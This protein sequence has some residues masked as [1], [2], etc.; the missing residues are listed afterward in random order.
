MCGRLGFTAVLAALV[1]ATPAA[2]Q[3]AFIGFE[4][5]QLRAGDVALAGRTNLIVVEFL[6]PKKTGLGKATAAL[7]FKDLVATVGDQPGAGVLSASPPI[8]QRIADF[9]ERDQHRAAQRIGQ[10]QR[11]RLVLWGSIEPFGDQLVVNASLT[12]LAATEDPELILQLA[13]QK[14]PVP[15]VASELPWTR[16][17]L[18]P[19][20]IRRAPYF[21][22]V[23]I[24]GAAGV[25]M[26]AAPE[27]SA[28]VLRTA[29]PGE[30]LAVRDMHEEWAVLADG[31]RRVF[32]D[33]KPRPD[34]GAAFQVM[35]RRVGVLAV[36]PVHAEPSERAAVVGRLEPQRVYAAF[37]RRSVDGQSWLQVDA[38]GRRGWIRQ[39]RA[40][41]VHDIAAV[42]LA[43]ASLRFAF[44]NS[45]AAEFELR[46]F[47]ARPESER[48]GVVTAGALQFLAATILRRPSS[49]QA[50]RDAALELLDRAVA[51]TPYDASALN[52]RAVARLGLRGGLAAIEDLEAALTIDP[53]NG[54]ARILAA[55]IKR[56]SESSNPAVVAQLKLREPEFL[57]RLDGLMAR[58]AAR[59]DSQSPPRRFIEDMQRIFE[60]PRR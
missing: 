28:A 37:G 25:P 35:P 52:L 10:E 11:G 18:P 51:E 2:S 46:R 41:A 38:G 5:G 56:A 43:A 36:E 16:F 14:Q 58:F 20:V 24:A 39:A 21:D 57:R 31:P 1:A 33:A 48:G 19:V 40:P 4:R 42:S 55:A 26:R 54:R 27:P 60:P 49:T 44:A 53:L 47:L 6:D 8:G 9:V 29:R 13:V 30:Q 32:V 23:A 50:E 15:D 59:G 3:E 17:D 22:R 7:L 34:S 12:M 45:E